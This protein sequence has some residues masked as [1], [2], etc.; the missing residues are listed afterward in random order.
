MAEGTF[1]RDAADVVF[2]H[3]SDH[4]YDLSDAHLDLSVDK[5]C[6]DEPDA[7]P[8]DRVRIIPK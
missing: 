5:L 4:L 2:R 8:P 7:S 6:N 3:I 1:D